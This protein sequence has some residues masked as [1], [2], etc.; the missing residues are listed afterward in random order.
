MSERA[1]REELELLG[2]ELSRAREQLARALATNEAQTLEEAARHEA[3]LN[4]RGALQRKRA[5][6]Q[7]EIALHCDER[8]ELEAELSR[9]RA[10]GRGRASFFSTVLGRRPRDA[11][12]RSWLGRFFAR[13][14]AAGGSER[15]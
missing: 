13:L 7:E 5:P 15:E 11:K 12:E 8:A 14:L 3:L 2:A 6:L 4:E 9:A 10:E 1:L